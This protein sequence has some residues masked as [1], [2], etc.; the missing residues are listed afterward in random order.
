MTQ[1]A[2]Q[3]RIAWNVVINSGK[4]A[5]RNFGID[6]YPGR[7]TRYDHI[8]SRVA[9]AEW[10]QNSVGPPYNCARCENRFWSTKR[11]SVA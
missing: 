8:E 9:G 3:G 1:R 5:A 6:D 11:Y 7:D 4:A 2:W 10:C